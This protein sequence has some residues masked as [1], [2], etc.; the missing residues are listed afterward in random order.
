MINNKPLKRAIVE[1]SIKYGIP[2]KFLCLDAKVNYE[3]FMRQ[4]INTPGDSGLEITEK[5]FERIINRL[6]IS[7]RFQFVIDG[8]FDVI[9]HNERLMNEGKEY[10]ESLKK[11]AFKTYAER[12]HDEKK[13]TSTGTE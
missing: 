11:L 6:G 4:Y 13:R 2:L 9:K 7:I 8:D 5:Q 3:N 10:F 12:K 1:R